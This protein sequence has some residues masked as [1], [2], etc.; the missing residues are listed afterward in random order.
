MLLRCCLHRQWQRQRQRNGNATERFMVCNNAATSKLSAPKMGSFTKRFAPQIY[1][2]GTNVNA[3]PCLY[4]WCRLIKSSE[5]DDFPPITN[6]ARVA[7]CFYCAAWKWAQLLLFSCHDCKSWPGRFYALGSG[8]VASVCNLLHDL[9]L[10][11]AHTQTHTRTH[12]QSCNLWLSTWRM[13]N[14]R[15]VDS[16]SR[17]SSY[18][19][20]TLNAF[21]CHIIKCFGAYWGF[22]LGHQLLLSPKPHG[23]LAH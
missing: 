5:C 18:S 17:R 20:L 16:K 14:F 13:C 9:L 6:A 21:C 7:R 2:C 12:M 11:R 22:G 8:A 1:D 23:A 3:S 19:K 10:S 15:D 4:A